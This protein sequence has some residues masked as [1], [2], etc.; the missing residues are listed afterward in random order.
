[1]TSSNVSWWKENV[2]EG[3]TQPPFVH[4]AWHPWSGLG[5][6]DLSRQETQEDLDFTRA[7]AEGR[8]TSIFGTPRPDS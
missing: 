6:V 5:E 8:K 3:P 7:F 1:V 4:E 2:D